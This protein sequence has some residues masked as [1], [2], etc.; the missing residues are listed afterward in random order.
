M[1]SGVEVAGVCVAS[2]VLLVPAV[3]AFRNPT[4]ACLY[5]KWM[6]DPVILRN[7]GS[8]QSSY[9]QKDVTELFEIWRSDPNRNLFFVYTSD[10]KIP[11]GDIS[12]DIDPSINSGSRVADL[13]MMIG[14]KELRSNGRRKNG[15]GKDALRLMLNYG[16]RD[17]EGKSR[18]L[19][20]T[21][22]R[23]TVYDFN[24]PG[25]RLY[26]SF[27]FEETQRKKVVNPYNGERCIDIYMS[28]S[29][30]VFTKS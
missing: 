6:N 5:T 10:N 8:A 19:G 1:D 17:L 27:G 14:E 26:R 18:G 21:E 29:K 20:L 24:L 22:V 2:K 23:L 11:I 3:E 28:L 15:Y 25:Y 7:T 4:L 13:S 9:T 16:F 30:D 12:L